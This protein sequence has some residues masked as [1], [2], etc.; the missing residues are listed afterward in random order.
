M[1]VIK[2]ISPG[3]AFKLGMVIYGI[4]GILFVLFFEFFLAA[5]MNLPGAT[6]PPRNVFPFGPGALLVLPLIYAL[7]GGVFAALG[8]LIYNVASKWVGGLQ[9]DIN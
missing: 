5:R 9:V 2:R 8:A 7:I 3:S 1:S 4:L 6:P